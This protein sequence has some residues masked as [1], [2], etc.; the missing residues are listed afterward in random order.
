M[1]DR[2]HATSDSKTPLRQDAG[3]ALVASRHPEAT[4]PLFGW[5]VS[6]DNALFFLFARGAFDA[7]FDE[8]IQDLDDD[9]ALL[10]LDGRNRAAT[11]RRRIFSNVKAGIVYP[12]FVELR[13]SWNSPSI[14][15]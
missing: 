6:G 8:A 9:A 13:H 7:G 4:G 14:V 3:G 10:F 11:H 12:L 2:W 1:N 15:R 5:F